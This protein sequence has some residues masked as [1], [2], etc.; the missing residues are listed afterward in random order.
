MPTR[1]V[2]LPCT[3]SEWQGDHAPCTSQEE[4]REGAL[5]RQGLRISG[6]DHLAAGEG[7]H[8]TQAP[9]E[10]IH[11]SYQHVTAV[12]GPNI[13]V[14]AAILAPAGGAGAP[15]G[16][17]RHAQPHAAKL[18]GHAGARLGH[19]AADGLGVV[20]VIADVAHLPAHVST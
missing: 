16:G 11:E 7:D 17:A 1:R 20:V 6:R 12:V 14:V 5:Q 10:S 13:A 2:K 4:T 18:A 15:P 3:A 9:E 8:A 19:A